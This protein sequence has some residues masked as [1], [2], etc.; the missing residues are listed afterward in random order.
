VTHVSGDR[1]ARRGPSDDVDVRDGAAPHIVIAESLAGG[2]P[3]A[4]ERLS[5]RVTYEPSFATDRAGLIA[6]VRDAAVLVVRNVVTVD[7][8]LIDAAPHMIAIGRLGTGLD[9]I[10]VAYARSRGIAIVDAA[11]ANANAV[12]EYVLAVLLAIERNL[13]GFD[14][15][16]RD[17]GWPRFAHAAGE[18]AGKTLGIAGLGRCGARV[19]RFGVALGLHVLGLRR[20]PGLPA[21]LERIG[22]ERV[23]KGE[24]LER[25]HYLVLLL[26][27]LPAGEPFL[28]AAAFARMRA[29]AVLVSAGRG[30]LVDERAL[31]H[32]LD[33]NRLRAA[34]LDTRCAEPPAA[35]DALAAHPKVL[36]TPHVAGLT[37]EAQARVTAIVAR[38]IGTAL[39]R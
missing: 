7:R 36:N 18:L 8:V 12:A 14:R 13:A 9:N 15:E 6:A 25:A 26:P 28:D 22:V 1:A 30:S 37:N 34:V 39:I 31:L 21:D 24:L 23:A 3:E 32:A 2:S 33:T 4:F 20:T 19:A 17:G 16:V 38:G 29:D 5:A 11:D 27:P 35:G 10:D